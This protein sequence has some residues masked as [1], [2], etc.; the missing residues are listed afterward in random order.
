MASQPPACVGAPGHH[1]PPA[2]AAHT[3]PHGSTN[4][5][6]HTV[7]G[8]SGARAAWYCSE[9]LDVGIWAAESPIGKLVHHG[10]YIL[11][12]GTTHSTS[13]AYHVAEMSV[14]CGCIESFANEDRVVGIDGQVQ[15]VRGLA[16]RGGEC[17]VS[18]GKLEAALDRRRLQQR[19]SVGAAAAQLVLAN[20][21]WKV[22]REQLRS[23]CPQCAIKPQIR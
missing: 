13:T 4:L 17:P 10:G 14:P 1:R 5:T 11:A 3:S 20:D 16:F 7:T 6:A 22:R 18:I 23:A 12:L 8:A 19:G 2:G 9:H 21:L 15:A